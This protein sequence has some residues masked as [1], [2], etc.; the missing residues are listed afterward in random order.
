MVGWM[1]GRS[2]CILVEKE[3]ACGALQQPCAAVC[4]PTTIHQRT[5]FF[6]RS[7]RVQ[8]SNLS[9]RSTDTYMEDG[10]LGSSSCAVPVLL[11]PVIK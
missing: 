7:F 3:T 5:A 4:Q 1:D 6:L 11:V 8:G 9:H 2:A 10:L